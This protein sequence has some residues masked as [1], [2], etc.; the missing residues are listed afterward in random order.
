MTI[1]AV[2]VVGTNARF[3]IAET[4]KGP[5]TGIKNLICDDCP[6]IDDAINA[7]IKTSTDTPSLEIDDIS[8]AVGAP[9]K[10]DSIDV[11]NNHWPTLILFHA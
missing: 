9:V 8:I 3:G 10:G 5:L 2:D 6:R 11:T 4:Y 7:Y 1:I